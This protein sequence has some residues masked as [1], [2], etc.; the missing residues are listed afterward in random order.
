MILIILKSVKDLKNEVF[1]VLNPKS[2]GT[3]FYYLLIFLLEIYK[4]LLMLE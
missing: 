1:I 2:R 3:M 4:C